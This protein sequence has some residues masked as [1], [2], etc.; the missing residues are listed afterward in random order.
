MYKDTYIIKIY[1]SY[2]SK[3]DLHVDCE[4]LL[5]ANFKGWKSYIKMSKIQYM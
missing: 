2:A 3:N 4:I 1:N 5:R